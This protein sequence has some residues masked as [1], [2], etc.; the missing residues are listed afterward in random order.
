MHFNLS[1]EQEMLRDGVS[2]FLAAR[3]DL[4]RSRAAA[5]TGAGWQPE[6]WLGFAE[7]LGILGATLPESAG[8]MGG[9]PVEAMVIAEE[10][11]RALVIEPFI[12]TVV[13]AG[14]ML[15][16]AD[17]DAA[18]A[19]LDA[20]HSRQVWLA[21]DHVSVADLFVAGTIRSA[22]GLGVPWAAAPHTARWLAAVEALP[23]WVAAR[24]HLQSLGS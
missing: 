2:K 20:A 16:R 5:K 24:A 8:G 10:I 15:A 18:A 22:A 9:G 19:V 17:G 21:G 13:V 14:G 12:D 4:E 11:G 7:E 3:Y 23:G 6:V 1:A